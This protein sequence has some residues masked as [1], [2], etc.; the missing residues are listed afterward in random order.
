MRARPEH[1]DIRFHKDNPPRVRMMTSYLQI[2]TNEI[3]LRAKS[4]KNTVEVVFEPA[5]HFFEFG[6]RRV[7]VMPPI[8]RAGAS[9]F[10]RSS[11]IASSALL[12]PDATDK[13]RA[14]M[15][16]LDKALDRVGGDL[17]TMHQIASHT[18]V[19]L[20]Q[21]IDQTKRI[22]NKVDAGAQRLDSNNR[23]IE[24]IMRE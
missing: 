5:A 13:Q 22:N 8:T 9:T 23:R 21:Q 3:F 2:V 19:I 1:C 15:E 14:D 11:Q 24:N 7:S 20:D 10:V 17:D 16:K 18:G 12:S 6:D 4:L